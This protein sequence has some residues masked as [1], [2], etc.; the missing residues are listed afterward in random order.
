MTQ[1]SAGGNIPLTIQLSPEVAKRLKAAAEALKRP[2]ADV[3]AELLERHLPRPQSGGQQKGA[4][5][6][7]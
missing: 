5:P 3:A 7:T 1:S 2:A 6:Y 4:I